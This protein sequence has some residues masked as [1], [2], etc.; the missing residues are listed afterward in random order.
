MR[1]ENLKGSEIPLVFVPHNKFLLL[2][3]KGNLKLVSSH[4]SLM[5]II[6]I[7]FGQNREGRSATEEE[8]TDVRTEI[9]VVS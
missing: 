1:L 8:N 9:T 3:T 6:S 2:L 7:N 5:T 4:W